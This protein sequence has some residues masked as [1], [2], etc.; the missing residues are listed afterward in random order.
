MTRLKE[1]IIPPG[2]WKYTT[3]GVEFHE[4][5]PDKLV[6]SIVKY[7][8]QNRI[9]IGDPLREIEEYFCTKFPSQCHGAT[10]VNTKQPKKNVR[11]IDKVLAWAQWIYSTDTETVDDI[12]ANN[13]SSI[14]HACECQV[15]WQNDCPKCINDVKRI[16]IILRKGKEPITHGLKGCRAWEFD[17]KTACFMK[18]QPTTP[19]NTVPARC[20]VNK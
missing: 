8:S 9:P 4:G 5:A 15:E 12:T 1:S 6:D 10:A 17:S 2:G 18:K 13:R 16:L 19:T 20:W 14:C 7:R 3:N 11:F